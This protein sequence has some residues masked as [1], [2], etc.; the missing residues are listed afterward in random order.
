MPT[1][2]MTSYRSAFL[3][4]IACIVLGASV[5]VT[6]RGSAAPDSTR[7]SQ[8]CLACHA[9]QDVSLAA[10][11]HRLPGGAVDGAAARIAC[12]DCHSG[13]RRHWEDDPAANP[14]VDPSKATAAA[15]ARLCSACHQSAHQQNAL[16]K[17]AHAANDVNCSACHSIHASKHPAL[18]KQAESGL[19]LGCHRDVEVQ[20]SKSYRH[21]V[22]DGI[23]KCSE[24]HQTLDTTRRPLATNGTNV[25]MKCHGEFEGPF[26]YEHPATVDYSTDEG[27]CV[28][29]HE[30]HG[31]NLPRMLKQPYEAPHFQLCTQ[32]HS[33]PPRH[34]SNSQ[35]GTDWASWACNK[36]HTDIH[37]SY[38]SRL[39]L[40]ESLRGCF[41][42]G[43][44]Q[45]F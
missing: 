17:N 36:C 12:T 6:S 32:C 9:G 26:P 33:V 19:C 15:E 3:L 42:A 31:S 40:S 11:G 34:L 44:H 35:H 8:A 10:T 45:K 1:P 5:A 20:F 30:P 21:P 18:L 23:V 7:V 24:C 28:A 25:C 13:D 43:C 22:K 29:C 41:N 2:H 14:M 39:F 16:E 4:L 38:T 27:G 37:G